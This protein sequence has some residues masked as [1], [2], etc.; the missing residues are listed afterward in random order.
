MKRQKEQELVVLGRR[1]VLIGGVVAVGL[2]ACGGNGS[3]V[4]GVDAGGGGADAGSGG[5]D[6]GMSAGNCPSTALVTDVPTS[7]AVGSATYFDTNSLFVVRDANG[8]FALSAICT[9]QGCT[10]RKSSGGFFCP[11]H[12]ATY[13]LAGN[14]TG[15]PAPMALPQFALCVTGDG[16]VGVDDSTNVDPGTRLKI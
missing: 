3:G 10:V 6:A 14:V 11:C 1:E 5:Q 2:V 12:G 7:F 15:G 16:K 4:P 8:L 13:D 9:H